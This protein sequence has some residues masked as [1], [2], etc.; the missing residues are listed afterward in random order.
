MANNKIFYI[1][2]MHFDDNT[3]FRWDKRN[4]PAVEDF[5]DVDAK[6]A[7]MIERWN[8][9]VS[10]RDHV[11]IL[12]D[13]FSC[14]KERAMEI[15]KQ[16]HG[17]K[18]FLMGN[19]DRAWLHEIADTRKFNILECVDYKKISDNGRKVIM[20]H[21]PIMFWEGQH[22]G[23]FHLY[24]HVHGSREYD[25]FTKFGMGL[26]IDRHI[27]EFRAFNVGAM[28]NSY[29]PKT[30]DELITKFLPNAMDKEEF[31]KKNR[32]DREWMDAEFGPR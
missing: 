10:N 7:A 4:N 19:H 6:N 18:H 22:E 26:E 14:S 30:L 17:A 8:T 1:S 15:L 25:Q 16:L 24:G 5:A 9:R 12:G 27:P 32:A 23:A 3:T 31:K 2:D 28:V 20:S 11:Y 29:E 13:T 21:Y